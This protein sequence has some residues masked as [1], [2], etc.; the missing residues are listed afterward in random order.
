M[1]VELLGVVCLLRESIC[2]RKGVAT[3]VVSVCFVPVKV[4]RTAARFGYVH[5]EAVVRLQVAQGSGDF[6][7]LLEAA[8]VAA[9]C[10]Y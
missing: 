8:L 4:Y 1:N 10:P 9:E 7:V 3:V 5:G 2:W 6:V